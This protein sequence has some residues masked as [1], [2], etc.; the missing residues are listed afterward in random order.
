MDTRNARHDKEMKKK[1]IFI[2]GSINAGKSTVAQLLSEKLG[3]TAILEVDRL[4]DCISWMPLE[5]SIGINL[6]NTCSLIRNFVRHDINVVIPYPLSQRNYEFVINLLNNIDAQMYFFTLD[7]TLKIAMS[8]R[9]KRKLTTYE[10]ERI[11]YHYKIG[12]HKPSF[13]TIIN[14]TNETPEETVKKIISRLT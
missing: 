7:P 14:N 12:I 1:I 6:E 5:D 13:G 8:N 9:G 11:N 10:V 3:R 2:N 4:R